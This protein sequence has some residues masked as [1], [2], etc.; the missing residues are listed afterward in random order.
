MA[1]QRLTS[2][3]ASASVLG[4]AGATLAGCR[5]GN[6]GPYTI[7]EAASGAAVAE[8]AGGSSVASAVG[9][10]GVVA[11]GVT[12]AVVADVSAAH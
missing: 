4:P 10:L 5:N 12:A 11:V 8:T 7:G 9:L 2:L 3:A 1:G 6:D